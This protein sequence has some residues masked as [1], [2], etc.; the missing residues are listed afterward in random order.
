MYNTS[1]DL[2]VLDIICIGVSVAGVLYALKGILASLKEKNFGLDILAIVAIIACLMLGEY[3]AAVVVVVMT[4]TGDFLE[5][6]AGKRAEKELTALIDK[7]P[8]KAHLED[9]TDI[10]AKDVAVGDT[11]RVLG[12]EMVPVDGEALAEIYLDEASLTGESM[13]VLKCVG[14]AV[15]S[16]SV[17]SETFTMRATQTADDSSYQK[18]THLVEL[19][20]ESK[21][22]AVRLA[23][24][25]SIPFTL[26]SLTIASA[27]WAISGESLRFAEVLVLATP[28]P[29]LIAAP[30]AFLAGLS[31]SAKSGI[32]VKGGGTLERM[33]RVKTIAFDKTGTITNGAPEFDRVDLTDIGAQAGWTPEKVLQYAASLE[34][35]SNH[36]FAK[37]ITNQN[38][39]KMLDVQN[40]KE[41]FGNGVIGYIADERVAVQKPPHSLDINPGETAV[42]LM[43]AGK[44]IAHI[45]LVDHIRV[46][47]AS[48]VER[49]RE[50][51]VQRM[52]ML[53]GDKRE[54]AL[55]I[56]K[57]VGIDHV[58]SNLLPHQK[59][60]IIQ[61]LENAGSKGCA[62]REDCGLDE[63]STKYDATESKGA[64][65]AFVGDGVND[66]PVLMAADVG[67][68]LGAKG[69]S[70]ASQSA[71]VVIM[72]DTFALV[73]KSLE[74]SKYTMRIAKQ[75]MIGGIALSIALM[76]VAS[77]GYI[78]AVFGAMLQEVLDA[79][80][81][82]NGIRA[83]SSPKGK[84]LRAEALQ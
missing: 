59:Y 32:I 66:A 47:A 3:I 40:V 44:D 27:A 46:D 11:L 39:L 62:I 65:I 63:S 22:P 14:E 5:E 16:G 67:I 24:T 79:A 34:H 43:V 73:P 41:E 36:I 12:G 77:F 30:V 74:I 1:I 80:A 55:H 15:L 52:L 8:D 33:A 83:A 64:Q 25:I 51:G 69:A 29:L 71:D 13:P 72:R 84:A 10:L 70:A 58:H 68:A 42:E 20:K 7:T 75:S 37:T 4:L 50:L 49:I 60:E 35:F 54:T 17:A 81:I 18:I 28:C 9:G 82:I 21:A 48:S 31:R 26:V 6:Y 53:T 78:P 19:A 45:I 23:N 76:L 61:G 38:Q 57:Q 56:A 2:S